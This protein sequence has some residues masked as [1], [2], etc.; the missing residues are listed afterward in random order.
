MARAGVSVAAR[1]DVG[2]EGLG[3]Y[4]NL[5]NYRELFNHGQTRMRDGW[6]E[7]R[8]L[9]F[10]GS[11]D[12]AWLKPEILAALARRCRKVMG[13]FFQLTPGGVRCA[14]LPRGYHLP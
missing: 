11:G 6:T 3:V 8:K 2:E 10:D 13:N 14:D 12:S 5:T 9:S 1:W 7:M 4:T